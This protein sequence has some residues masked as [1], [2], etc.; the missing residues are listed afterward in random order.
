VLFLSAGNIHRAYGDKTTDEVTGAIR[1]L[2]LS[3]TLFL[4]GFLAITGAPP[5]GPFV[6]E[7]SILNGAMSAGRYAIAA[8]FL[9]LLLVI[10]IGMG[11]TVLAVTQGRAPAASRTTAY[12]DGL[13]TGVPIVASFVLVLLLGVYIPSPLRTLLSDAVRFLEVRP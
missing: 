13:L 11:R 5:F 12:R 10:F 9:A 3:G 8:A 6:S 7:F 2:P 4:L 1:R